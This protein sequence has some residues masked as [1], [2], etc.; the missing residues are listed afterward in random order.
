VAPDG[1]EEIVFGT[2]PGFVLVQGP[3]RRVSPR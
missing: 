2:T 1:E 3:N